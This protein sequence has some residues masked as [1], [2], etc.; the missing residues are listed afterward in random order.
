MAQKSEYKVFYY[1]GNPTFKSKNKVE[2]L[3]RDQVVEQSATISIPANSY[4]VL[5]NKDE[6]P[7]GLNKEGE[8]SIADI[9]KLYTNM[10]DSN[11]TEE[12][13]A[14]IASSML[15]TNDKNRRSGGVYRAVG[16]IMI[17]PFDAA[18]ILDKKI[19][20]EWNNSSGKQQYLKIFDI[21]TWDMIC[22]IPSTDSLYS[23][24]VAEY[25]LQEGKEYAWIITH[26]SEIPQSGSE[27]FVFTI[28]D[29]QFK[30]DIDKK[31]KEANKK[32]KD[33]Q[34]RKMLKLRVYIDSDIYPIPLYT[35]L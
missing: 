2:K 8:Y 30:K 24:D 19:E 27:L 21:E 28:S 10:G 31:L 23:L 34:M 7:V 17:N 5:M 26:T 16:D 32:S 13:F 9:K 33:V 25:N 12:F 35:D 20:F 11:L 15:D 14:Y 22:N 29:K 1:S 4:V 6:V 18:N 3:V